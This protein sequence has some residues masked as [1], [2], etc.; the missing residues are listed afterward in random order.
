[1]TLC[2]SFVIHCRIMKSVDLM[3]RIAKGHICHNPWWALHLFS[4]DCVILGRLC[5]SREQ[6]AK[7]QMRVQQIPSDADQNNAFTYGIVVI[8]IS[9]TFFLAI[10][11]RKDSQSVLMMLRIAKDEAKNTWLWIFPFLMEV[12][13]TSCDGRW[14]DLPRD[15]AQT[16]H[17]KRFIVLEVHYTSDKAI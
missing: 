9:D 12:I 10:F 6:T 13:R 3:G 2:A 1:M 11:L 8:P 14:E 17:Q 16:L 5:F 15:I 7:L 4:S